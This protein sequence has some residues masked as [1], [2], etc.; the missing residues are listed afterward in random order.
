MPL[1]A[2]HKVCNL[3]ETKG[4]ILGLYSEIN[5]AKANPTGNSNR[6]RDENVGPAQFN[7]SVDINRL[8][9]FPRIVFLGTVSA[10]ASQDRNHTSILVHST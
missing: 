2:S 9:T 8:K 1:F 5:L 10:I 7:Q 4:N 3:E 6:G